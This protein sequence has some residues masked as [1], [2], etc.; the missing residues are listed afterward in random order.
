[1]EVRLFGLASFEAWASP[2]GF[3]VVEGVAPDLDAAWPVAI[4]MGL[5]WVVAAALGTA[6]LQRRKQRQ[7]GP[8][9][10]LAARVAPALGLLSIQ[11]DESGLVR[12]LSAAASGF[13][14][15]PSEEASGRS[16]VELG[17]EFDAPVS[18]QH[19]QGTGHWRTR[20]GS[21]LALRWCVASDA[22]GGSVL[23]AAPDPS[24][25]RRPG[26]DGDG[27]RTR[28]S[29]PRIASWRLDLA[30]GG[31]SWHAAPGVSGIAHD[32]I[33]SIDD[34]L[35]AVPEEDR[36][37]VRRV[38][39]PTAASARPTTITHCMETG[40]GRT[41]VWVHDIT[42]AECR[43]AGRQL[44]G[45]VHDVTDV[46]DS[47]VDVDDACCSTRESGTIRNLVHRLTVV[48]TTD[49]DGVITD[50]NASFCR[51]MGYDRTELIGQTHRIVRSGVHPAEFWRDLW[52]TVRSGQ[53][54]RGDI[55]NRAKD[56]RLLWMDTMIAPI[57]DGTGTVTGYVSIRNDVTARVETE[58]A[59]EHARHVAIEANDAK[60]AFLAKVSHELRT[61]LAAIL[62][63]ASILGDE[64]PSNASLRS[65]Q[66]AGEHL[67][68]I[69][70]DLLDLAKI[71]SG[72]MDLREE[73]VPVRSFFD[74]LV[75]ILLAKARAKG[76]ALACEIAEDVPEAVLVDP[77]RLR[78]VVLNVSGNALKFTEDGSVTIRVSR[79]DDS[80]VVDVVDTGCG[81]PGE[82]HEIVMQAFRQS[83]ST[84][85]REPG[86]GLGM[87]ISR[88]LAR[89]MG[90]D[91]RIERSAPGE[92]THVR[93]DVR[94]KTVSPRSGAESEA[95][96]RGEREP[97]AALRVLL[98][99][100]SADNRRIVSSFLGR[101]GADVTTAEDGTAAL[102]LFAPES[103]GGFDLILTDLRMPRT[104]GIELTRILRAQGVDA[105]ILALSADATPE[106][107]D[108][109][110]GAGC[111]AYL[112]KPV[113]PK[114]LIATCRA[115]V[116]E[117]A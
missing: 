59:L 10:D 54:W 32:A 105:P 72:R 48:T 52:S 66:D 19:G 11:L 109:C 4:A 47:L 23:L 55:C 27:G 36:D 102:E 21:R 91:V 73:A 112:P 35:A 88:E 104:D 83:D 103:T 33:R 49:A 45:E 29:A 20:A 106:S 41:E 53:V 6:L 44:R 63:Y 56:G 18:T 113:R 99:D 87:S 79:R 110:L 43:G 24:P 84:A 108:Q 57:V 90:G 71:E 77:T 9:D 15:I 46:T 50:A 12:S 116:R 38:L 114:E 97:L 1:M 61:P 70:N 2:R 51:A 5:G 89:R 75:A 86:T 40:S 69:V 37:R 62:G 82:D 3:G 107:R 64:I 42:I 92:G 80:L 94:A 58:I 8:D 34:L 26:P 68:A 67:L 81:I 28:R 14:G 78:Q 22:A 25:P 74:G 101:A 31:W 100:D 115:L 39:S 98:V 13:S 95:T 16:L 7:L 60:S 85:S 93:I 17:L 111:D 65:I 117:R 76:I 30:T 96:C